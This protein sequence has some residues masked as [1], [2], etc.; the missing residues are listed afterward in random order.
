LQVAASGTA[1]AA[2]SAAST[3]VFFLCS[4]MVCERTLLLLCGPLA[5]LQ[6]ASGQGGSNVRGG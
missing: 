6:V 1:A 5:L 3:A 2:A 4:G